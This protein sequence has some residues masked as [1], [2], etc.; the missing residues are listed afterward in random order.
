MF[1][2]DR[3]MFIQKR[4]RAIQE[5]EHVCHLHPLRSLVALS[6]DSQSTGE[7]TGSNGWLLPPGGASTGT[8]R[9]SNH[10]LQWWNG[11]W[12]W[13]GKKRTSSHV[14][15]W[16]WGEQ[17]RQNKQIYFHLGHQQ[18]RADSIVINSLHEPNHQIVFTALPSSLISSTAVTQL[19]VLF[20]LQYI[21]L[22]EYSCSGRSLW[23][24]GRQLRELSDLLV[25]S[26]RMPAAISWSLIH[27]QEP[28]AIR[29]CC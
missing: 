2:S 12:R 21:S 25:R 16:I 22:C 3:S 13:G 23:T 6:Q 29:R 18:T 26:D 4:K 10:C 20:P 19:A 8:M 17:I 7:T 28:E 5:T 1:P 9:Q 11:W 14:W 24:G 27:I 15:F